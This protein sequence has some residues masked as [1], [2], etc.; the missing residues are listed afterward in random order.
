MNLFFFQS[1]N[2]MAQKTNTCNFGELLKK[3]CHELHYTRSCGL[4]QL[5]DYSE[6]TQTVYLCQ[7]GLL[8]HH[9]ENMSI[10][11]HHE[12]ALG[13]VFE[14]HA[15]RYCIILK[16]HRRKTQGL[17]R[18]TLN[19]AQQ[20]KAK[21][22]DVQPGHMDC[23]QCITANK[24]IINASSSD[25]E[26]E[27]TPMDGIYEVA[28]DDATYK[29]YETLTKCLNMSLEMVGMSPVNL[30]GAP[31]HSHAT[32]TK[33]KLGK[34]VNM[35]K[36]IIAE[37]YNVNRDMLDTSDSVFEEIDA[38]WKGAEL[39][40]LHDAMREK[41]KTALY[42]EKIQILPLV[43]DKWSREYASK[44]FHLREYLI[45]TACELKKVGGILAEP[46]PKKR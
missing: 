28:L 5:V 20:L 6:D 25:T 36:S 32:S 41:L 43:A 27:E 15:T 29:V 44:Q 42:P 14:Q 46:V 24:N 12:Q 8:E 17:K 16:I 37:A 10:C 11:L 18:I 26:V 2:L 4:K 33:Q 45:Q 3:S 31:Q 30:H 7:A 9:G 21:N 1:R 38:Q 19:I 13:N 35:Y 39:D 23:C 22:F 34:V 40:Q